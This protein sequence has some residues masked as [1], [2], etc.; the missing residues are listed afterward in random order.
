MIKQGK[1]CERQVRIFRP[2][3]RVAKTYFFI[4]VLQIA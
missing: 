2:L 4:V 3:N 1:V